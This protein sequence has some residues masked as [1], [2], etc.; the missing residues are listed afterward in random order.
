MVNASLTILSY[1]SLL[2]ILQ[3]VVAGIKIFKNLSFPKALLYCFCFLFGILFGGYVFFQSWRWA[4]GSSIS[5]IS[6][7]LMHTYIISTAQIF[8]RK[9]INKIGDRKSL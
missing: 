5:I 4:P 7:T 6:F 2:M 9:Y 8:H 1:W 3:G